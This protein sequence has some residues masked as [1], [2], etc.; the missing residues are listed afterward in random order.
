[1]VAADFDGDWPFALD[2]LISAGGFP[3]RIGMRSGSGGN[4]DNEGDRE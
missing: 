4:A 3:L 1:M 2:G